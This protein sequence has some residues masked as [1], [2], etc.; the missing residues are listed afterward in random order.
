MCVLVYCTW[1]S[2][3]ERVSTICVHNTMSIRYVSGVFVHMCAP[4]PRS[5]S[6]DPPLLNAGLT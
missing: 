4:L 3:Y 6:C 2:I 5:L 1:L